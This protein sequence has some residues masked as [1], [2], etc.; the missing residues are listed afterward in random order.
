MHAYKSKHG[1]EPK[2]I[3]QL[4]INNMGDIVKSSLKGARDRILPLC[5][6][7]GTIYVMNIHNTFAI[8]S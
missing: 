2:T 7:L 5:Y 8:H 3:A 6:F 4:A 1:V